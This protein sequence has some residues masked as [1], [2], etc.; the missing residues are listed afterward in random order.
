MLIPDNMLRIEELVDNLLNRGEDLTAYY[1]DIDSNMH[2]IYQVKTGKPISDIPVDEDGYVT[3]IVFR[4]VG[5]YYGIYKILLGY[6]AS[7]RGNRNDAYKKWES[8]RAQYYEELNGLT[9]DIIE[10]GDG[11]NPINPIST[12]KQTFYAL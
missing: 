5:A 1:D 4:R 8:W 12:V 3:S 7:G 10:G 11:T 6:N 2:A 9:K